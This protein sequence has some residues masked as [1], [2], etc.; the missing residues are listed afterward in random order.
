MRTRLRKCKG[1]DAYTLMAEC[2]RCGNPSSDPVPPRYS[3]EDRYGK[4]RRMLK[5]EM[6]D[7]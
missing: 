7:S 2:P 3:P 4:Y 6:E 1:C 5:K